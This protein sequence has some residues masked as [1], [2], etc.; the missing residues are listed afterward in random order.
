MKFIENIC[1]GIVSPP[2]L[3]YSP[4][5]LGTVSLIQVAIYLFWVGGTTS[6]YSTL[7]D[8]GF[9]RASTNIQRKIV[10]V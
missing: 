7:V 6:K 1:E 5:D 3:R 10:S 4:F 2:K 8:Y 9:K